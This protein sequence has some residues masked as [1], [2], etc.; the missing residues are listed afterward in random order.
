MEKN[1]LFN[2]AVKCIQSTKN[3]TIDVYDLAYTITGKNVMNMSEHELEQMVDLLCELENSHV[4]ITKRNHIKGEKVLSG[5]ERKIS[6]NKSYFHTETEINYP[7]LYRK[8]LGIDASFYIKN[9]DLFNKHE[10]YI[11]RLVSYLDKKPTGL[12][13]NEISYLIF[14]DEK[15]LT[16]QSQVK[17]V[18]IINNLSLSVDDLK[19]TDSI[20]PF[21][22]ETNPLG[23]AILIIENKDTCYTLFRLC[24]M[25]KNNIKGVLYGEGWAVLKKMAFL[26]VYNLEETETFIYFGDIDRE[27]FHI[28]DSLKKAYP[29][30]SISLSEL[31]YQE[32][33]VYPARKSGSR[34]HIDYN[35]ALLELEPPTVT[36]IKN[37]LDQNLLIPQEALNYLHAKEALYGHRLY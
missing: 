26:D 18:E 27:G 34:R 33:S 21:Y 25:W 29:Q 16:E 22:Y 30:L 32:L 17:G 6:I 5:I 11:K 37:V 10:D 14:Q 8:D 7:G 31:L 2:D 19:G 15:A 28:Y 24:K 13:L 9:P 35:H 36:K 3:K 1:D 20:T 12:T 23:D 4:I